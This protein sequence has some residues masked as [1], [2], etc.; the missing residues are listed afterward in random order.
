M[1]EQ[2]LREKNYLPILKMNDGRNVTIE[3]WRERRKELLCALETYSYGITPPEPRKVYGSVISQNSD[4][5]AG[6][7]LEQHIQLSFETKN[8]VCSFPVY[9]YI[10][11]KSNCPPVLLHLAF[12]PVPDRYIPVEEI[13]DAGYALVVVCYQDMVNDGLYG[14]FSDGIAAHFHTGVHRKCDEWGKIGMWAYGASRVL[15]YL[16]NYRSDTL[17]VSKV[18]VIGHSRLGKTALWAGA[19]DERFWC[20]IS[21]NSGYGGAASSKYSK[22]E[23]VQDFL[24]AGSWDWYCEN[25]KNYAGEKEEHKPYDQAYLLSLI[26]P[27]YL[28][29]GSAELDKGADPE[30]EFLTTLW[31]SQTWKF[32]GKLGLVVPENRMPIVGDYFGDGCIEYHYRAGKHYLSRED[33]NNYIRFLNDKRKNEAVV[34]DK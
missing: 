34:G 30:A 24:N 5:C 3:S 17:D 32:L 25:F 13:T 26:A 18:T 23:K 22:G 9:F 31:A 19:Q 2:K 6:K 28:C 33:W 14:N 21:N 16:I 12:R 4:L 10:P 15:D 29:I 8:G 1:L 20:T 11:N 27:R 7:V